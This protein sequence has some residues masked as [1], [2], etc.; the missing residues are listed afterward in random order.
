MRIF[1]IASVTDWEQARRD[2]TY[3]TSTPGLPDTGGPPKYLAPL[4]GVAVL[5]GL[6]IVIAART[7]RG[8]H[9]S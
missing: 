6:G 7:R 1:H 3:T 4:G 2:G 8:M 9:R 5:A